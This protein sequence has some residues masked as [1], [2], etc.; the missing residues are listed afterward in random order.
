MKK[1]IWFKAKHYGFGWYPCT[2]Q[3]WII[4]GIFIFSILISS[5]IID[6][7]F[8]SESTKMIVL[9]IEMIIFISILLYIGKSKGEKLGWRW[10]NKQYG[11][12]RKNKR[13]I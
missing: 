10:G 5:F 7:S 3:G 13:K 4:S 12:N 9:Y 1:E 2:W 11:R 6:N 8:K